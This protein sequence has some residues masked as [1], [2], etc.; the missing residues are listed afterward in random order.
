M[1]TYLKYSEDFSISNEWTPG[2]WVNIET[3]TPDEL[4]NLKAKFGLPEDFLND[5]Y[6][7]DERPRVEHN[8]GWDC[9][10]VP[11]KLLNFCIT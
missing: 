5:L 11:N 7:I 3:P 9:T 4:T 1:T 2:C 8:D 10:A 6:D